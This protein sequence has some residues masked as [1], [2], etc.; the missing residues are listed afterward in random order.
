VKRP[1]DNRKSDS[2]LIQILA[3]I[4]KNF[5]KRD[6]YKAFL[7]KYNA[8]FIAEYGSNE[9]AK[10]RKNKMYFIT[11]FNS[12]I[13]REIQNQPAPFIYERLGERYRHF[14]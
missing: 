10:F 5:E 14:Y 1:S 6:F 8:T 7:K 4:Y 11:E 2:E 3:T 13:H 9:L 12:L